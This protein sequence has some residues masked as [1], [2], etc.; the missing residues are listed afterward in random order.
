[1]RKYLYA[2]GFVVLAMGLPNLRGH[3]GEQDE[4]GKLMRKKL[5]HAQKVL[6]GIALN[7]FD[8]IVKNGDDLMLI[9]KMAEWKVVRTPQYEV[10]SN[11]FRRAIDDLIEK[12]Q[13]KNLDGATLAYVDITLTCVKCHKYVRDVR[14]TSLDGSS[15]SWT[16]LR[17]PSR[18][19]PPTAAFASK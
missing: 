14:R 11:T 15:P 16:S 12:A 4:L 13:A 3:G 1:M 2:L 10:Q 18:S 9:S 7:D 19:Q 6:E 17:Q 5:E 8:K